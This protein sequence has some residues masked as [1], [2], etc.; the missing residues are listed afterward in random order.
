MHRIISSTVSLL[1][2]LMI[3][4]ISGLPAGVV[5]TVIKSSAGVWQLMAVVLSPLLYAVLFAVTAGVLSLPFHKAIVKGKFPR[6]VAHPVYRGRRF[7]GTCWTALYYCK[8]VYYLVLTL[9]WLKWMTFRLFGY[10]GQMDFTIYPDTWIRDLPLL[11]FGKCVYVANR[12]TLGTNTPLKNGMI[13][14]DGIRL[15]DGVLI[16]HLTMIG[17]GAVVGNG[18]EI[19]SGTILG[20]RAKVGVESRVE[21]FS[22]IG[23]GAKLGNNVFVGGACL[24]Y[25]Y[26][27]VGDG[28]VISA[29]ARVGFKTKVA[30]NT[31][32]PPH[33]SVDDGKNGPTRKQMSDP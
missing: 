9:P 6:D 16:G 14:V 28:A 33:A 12:A 18:S 10:K 3:A 1:C 19:S 22:A 23:F 11:D 25:H 32:V 8:P 2:L 17:P 13:F 31:K 27:V 15:G 26:A 30:N 4:S 29:G 5:F 7:Y 21:P 20:T 24:I